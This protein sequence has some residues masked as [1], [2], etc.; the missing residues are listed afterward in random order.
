[1]SRPVVEV[2]IKGR[3]LNAVLDTGSRR[4]YIRS[5]LVDGYTK[6]SVQ[7]FEIKLGGEV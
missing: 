5:E 3:E 7:P 6:V 1:M 2:E 4:S